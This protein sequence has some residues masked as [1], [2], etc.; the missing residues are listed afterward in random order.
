MPN[1]KAT[2]FALLAVIV[3][4]YFL[5]FG[6]SAFLEP[7]QVKM[8]ASVEDEDLYL[9]SGRIKSLA[10]DFNGLAS[11]WYWISAL[12]YVGRKIVQSKDSLN[13]NDLKPLNPKQLYPMLD[14]ATTLDPQYMPAYKFGA[15]ILS[16][17]DEDQAITIIKKGIAENPQEW[18][19]YQH[20][21]YI[22]WQRK[23]YELAAEAYDKG[24]QIEGAPIFFKKMSANVR[25]EGGSRENARVIYQSIYEASEDDTTKELM[26][27]RMAQ[28]AAQYERDEM[29][30][31]LAA[32][33]QKTGKCP[34]DWSAVF[35]LLRG[36]KTKDDRPLRF[37]RNG[38]P[39]D[40]TDVPY[41]LGLTEKGCQAT[42]NHRVT[43]IPRD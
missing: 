6:L 31:V 22:Y 12:Q 18:R 10:G 34:A 16:T 21:G 42:L 14:R 7:R 39:L 43:K 9:S 27:L 13:I 24:G 15:V 4:G 32:V 19:F 25:L 11:D 38:A 20:L 28:I 37:D 3:A 1:R 35:P 40:P 30:R 23:D 2:T 17:I 29:D 8:D 41:L 36:L 5:V 33:V 26:F